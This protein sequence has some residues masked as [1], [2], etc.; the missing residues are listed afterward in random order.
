M[1]RDTED[2]PAVTRHSRGQLLLTIGVVVAVVVIGTVVL[3]NGIYFNQNAGTGNSFR[4]IKQTGT[5]HDETREGLRRV[6]F[7]INPRRSPYVSNTTLDK[8][9]VDLR[10]DVSTF[11]GAYANMTSYDTGAYVAVRVDGAKTIN[12]S[13]RT[14]QIGSGDWTLVEDIDQRPRADMPYLRLNVTDQSISGG[15]NFTVR[16]ENSSTSDS[17]AIQFNETN[18][19]VGGESTSL[20]PKSIDGTW[21]VITV[22]G[23]SVR[24]AGHNT[25]GCDV[26]PVDIGAPVEQVSI[27]NGS[28]AEGTFN[29][30]RGPDASFGSGAPGT[31]QSNVIVNP[32]IEI[33][34]LSADLESSATIRLMEGN[35]DR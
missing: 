10:T 18:V 25:T 28:Q 12:G 17:L 24:F 27:E 3:L 26:V 16:F 2:Q 32:A 15:D 6:F 8:A 5:V 34:Y 33:E 1:S 35:F 31:E 23:G 13:A 30:T 4:E 20:C 7:D 19:F 29:V 14:G 11:S 22:S 9:I 21:T